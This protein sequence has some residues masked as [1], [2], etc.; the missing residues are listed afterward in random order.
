MVDIASKAVEEWCHLLLRHLLAFPCD[1]G[2][3]KGYDC[4]IQFARK[5]VIGVFRENQKVVV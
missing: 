1:V 5:V 2:A 4:L 3:K